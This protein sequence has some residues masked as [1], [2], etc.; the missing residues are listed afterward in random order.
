[1]TGCAGFIGGHALEWFLKKGCE[2]IGVDKMTYASNYK[3]LKNIIEKKLSCKS[4][5]KI[6]SVLRNQFKTKDNIK[7]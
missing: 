6:F 4:D 5:E 2:V 3:R 1:M 7:L